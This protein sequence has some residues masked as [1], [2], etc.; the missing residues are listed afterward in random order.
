VRYVQVNSVKFFLDN[1][2]LFLMAGASGAGLLWPW[3]AQGGGRAGVSSDQAV[4]LINR[5]KAV[6]IDVSEATEFAAVH[7]KGAKSVPLST[8][9]AGVSGLPK[10]KTLPLVV[11]CATGARAHKAAVALRTMGFQETHVLSGGL[12]AWREAQ[13]P[14]ELAV[15]KKQVAVAQ[16]A[17]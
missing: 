14:I 16:V 5:K 13:L 7:A 8:L 2:Y 1:W 10:N 12:A 3:L 9:V 6:L 4:Q 17:P 15:E 11:M